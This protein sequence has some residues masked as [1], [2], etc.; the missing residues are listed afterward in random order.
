MGLAGYWNLSSTGDWRS[1]MKKKGVVYLIG[2]GPGDPGLFTLKGKKILGEAEV[3]IYDRLIN[4]RI[5][6]FANPEAELIYVGKASGEHV[7]SQDKINALM[8]EKAA[9]G[10]TVARLKGGDPFLYG[11]GG[12]EALYLRQHGCDFEIVPGVTSAIAVPAYA[13][14]P[15]T[16]R[17]ATSSFAVITGHE[18]PNKK[19]SSIKWKEIANG[20]GTLVFLMG[21]ENLIFICESLINNGKDASTPVALIRWGTLPCQEVITGTLGNIAGKAE[22]AG[23]K[24]PAVIVIGE[25]VKLREQLA[26][27]EEKPLWGKRIVVTRARNQASLLVDKINKLGGEAIEFPSIRIVKEPDLS[28]LHDALHTIDKYSWLVFTSVNSVDIF[29][30][31]MLNMEMDIRELKGI[32]ICAIGP[33]TKEKLELRGLRVD[34]TPD[35]YRAEG[36]LEEL[37]RR[38]KPGQSVLLPRARGARD[39]LPKTIRGWGLYVDEVYLYE[40]Q[41]ALQGSEFSREKIINGHLDYVTFTSSSTVSNFV[42]IIGKENVKKID[43]KAK[44]V[45][46]G[47]ITADK[48]RENE[49]TVDIVADHYTIDGLVEAIVKDARS[50]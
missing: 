38:V 21:I 17:D 42:K 36:I 13:G 16:H 9:E 2:A 30:E 7:F 23:F 48:A 19:E 15:V 50:V 10:K 22:E 35:E 6:S 43:K 3:I 29:F 25:V 18:K 5:L 20:I 33:A 44:V 40:A 49:F 8:A 31:E 34:V 11:R 47:P 4:D 32:R 27:V 12:E 14:I 46:I 39:I 37:Y 24:P 26:W 45:C 28:P 41:A 1:I